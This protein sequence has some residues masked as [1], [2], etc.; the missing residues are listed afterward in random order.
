MKTYKVEITEEFIKEAHAVAS[1]EWRTKIKK[2]V[3]DAFEIEAGNWYKYNN[4]VFFITEFDKGHAY[5]YGIDYQENWLDA[6][7]VTLDL[8]L[9]NKWLVNDLIPATQKEVEAMLT[10]ESKKRGLV[11]G[12][13]FKGLVFH[14]ECMINSYTYIVKDNTLYSEL[15]GRGGEA[16]FRNG[17]WAEPI[18]NST[19]KRIEE[20]EAELKQLKE[21]L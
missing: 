21:S 5:G 11:K 20:I 6:R 1:D 13:K 12:V 3:P 7:D 19:L 14:E 18:Q 16:L 10:K 4:R 2:L 9:W 17:D 15:E 8:C